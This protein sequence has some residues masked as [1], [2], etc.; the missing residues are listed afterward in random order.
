MTS[1]TI[2]ER[3]KAMVKLH[4]EMEYVKV[5]KP[6]V[7]NFYYDVHDYQEIGE[8]RKKRRVRCSRLKTLDEL[9]IVIPAGRKCLRHEKKKSVILG[10]CTS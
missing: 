4:R 6:P 2:K 3:N 5:T 8:I 1:R 10:C 7:E 9:V